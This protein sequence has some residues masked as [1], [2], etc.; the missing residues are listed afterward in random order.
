MK[1]A[2]ALML[3]VGTAQPREEATVWV[4]LS[5]QSPDASPLF[6]Q[7]RGERV[8]TVLLVDRYFGSGE[9]AAAFLNSVRAAGELQVVDEE[10]LAKAREFGIRRLPA[11]AVVREGRVHVAGGTGADVK[12]LLRCSK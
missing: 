11:V 2:M 12:E 7:L 4:F 6:E 10:G 1:L 3:A 8:R 5:P 9:P